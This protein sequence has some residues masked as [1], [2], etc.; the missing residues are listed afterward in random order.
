MME[1]L[2]SSETSVLTR[3]TRRNIPEG[4]ILLPLNLSAFSVSVALLDV[5]YEP[6]FC[7][8]GSDIFERYYDLVETGWGRDGAHPAGTRTLFDYTVVI[9]LDTLVNVPKSEGMI[10]RVDRYW[11]RYRNA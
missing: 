9:T 8:S 5:W 11:F 7:L 10:R 6:S 2:S 4:A 3:A 1:V